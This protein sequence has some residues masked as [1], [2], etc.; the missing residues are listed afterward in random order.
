MRADVKSVV[1][2]GLVRGGWWVDGDFWAIAMYSGPS[3]LELAPAPGVP[4]PV[5]G[6]R[7]VADADAGFVAD[8]FM[9]RDG[10]RWLLFFE[11]WNRATG[12]GDIAV[13]DSPDAR[14]WTYRR[15]VLSEPHHLSY[16]QVIAW[17]GAHYLVPETSGERRV[18]L[19]RA[20]DWPWAWE[21]A[22]VLL[23]GLPFNDATLF[24]HGR[25]WWLLT[26]T[27]EQVASDTLR[28]YTAT[29]I[30]GPW[31]EHPASPVVK[32]DATSARPGGSVIEHDGR[33]L[34]F[35][36]D[37][38][39]D[40]GKRVRA[41]EITE[42]TPSTYAERPL[43]VALEPSGSGWNGQG[44]HQLD[45]H[46]VG[47]GRWLAVVDGRPVPGAVRTPSGRLPRVQRPR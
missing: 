8:P 21:P 22:A 12:K 40:Y 44:M 15:I 45:A 30:T 4:V 14:T 3:P 47:D 34:R 26:E 31:E 29:D 41:F 18:T 10:D 11:V 36:Q 32:G 35:A 38:A 46:R 9:V 13:A 19:Y 23:D 20:T 27:A 33:L 6:A 43:G 1:R 24:R 7:D 17:D 37:C 25:R 16:P 2:R 42:L 39:T 5:L 28:L